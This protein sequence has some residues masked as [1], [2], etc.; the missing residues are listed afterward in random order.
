MANFLLARH[1]AGENGGWGSVDLWS[2]DTAL[3]GDMPPVLQFLCKDHFYPPNLDF[4]REIEAILGSVARRAGLKHA[5]QSLSRLKSD[6][7]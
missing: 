3:A 5:D 7:N 4:K 1:N 6:H 2:V